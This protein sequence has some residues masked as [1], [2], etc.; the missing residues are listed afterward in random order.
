MNVLVAGAGNVGRHLARI[1]DQAGH[2]VTLVEKDEARVEQ[3]HADSGARVVHG[4]ASEPSLLE[5]NGI[6]AMDVVVATTGDDED[7]LVI[8]NLAKFEFAVPRV[9]ARVKNAA[10]AWLYEPDLG[11]DILVSAPHTIARLIE[12]QVAAGDVVQLLA[13]AEGHA[14][15]LETTLPTDSPIA[16]KRVREVAWPI[17]CV[18]AVVIRGSRVLPAP[19]E[20]VLQPGDR[21]LCVTDPAQIEPLH[22]LLGATP[23][24]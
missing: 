10:N 14:A 1:L 15:L 18:P 20:T 17:D 13:L 19:A 12:E 4:D 6:R 2:T 22:Q 24:R 21:L 7:N 11:V 9:V 5:Q 23:P 3:A 8:A 16:G